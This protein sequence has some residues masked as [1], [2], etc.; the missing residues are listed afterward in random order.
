[1]GDAAIVEILGMRRPANLAQRR[2]EL[3]S[4]GLIGPSEPYGRRLLRD[5]LNEF[6][7]QV[8]DDDYSWTITPQDLEAHTVAAP[9]A[10]DDVEEHLAAQ[11]E[12]SDHGSCAMSIDEG[13]DD[14]DLIEHEQIL[15]AAV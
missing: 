11:S 12:P 5:L 1:M 4:L 10:A 15:K 8:P 6:R 13:D 2:R 3:R 14:Q 7:S 9:W